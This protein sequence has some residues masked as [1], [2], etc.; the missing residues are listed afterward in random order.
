MSSPQIDP[1]L[2]GIWI[3]PGEETTYE[4]EPDGSYHVADPAQ[5]LTVAGDG[6]TMIWGR[7]RLARI[8]GDGAAPLGAWRDRDH[9]DEWL[10][11]A[12]GTYLQRWSDGEKTTGIWVHRDSDYSLWTREYRGQVET[13]GARITFVLPSEPAVTYGY[14]ADAESWILLDPE[15]W[16]KLVEYRRP[17]SDASAAPAHG[18]A[19]R[20]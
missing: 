14:T 8:G 5:P 3:I 19:A 20:G 4:I 12:D 18:G 15:T 11:Q 16:D 7:T 10:F 1:D 2:P 6:A 17:A 9:G 13:D